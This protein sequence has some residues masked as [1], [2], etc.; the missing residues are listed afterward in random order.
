M[1]ST[2]D[3][4]QSDKPHSATYSSILEFQTYLIPSLFNETNQSKYVSSLLKETIGVGSEFFN[5]LHQILICVTLSL[6]RSI[7]LIA[8]EDRS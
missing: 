5:H 2:D 4:G 6:N 3:W 7:T 1:G 8:V